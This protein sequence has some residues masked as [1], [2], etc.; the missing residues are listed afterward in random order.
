MPQFCDIF[1]KNVPIPPYALCHLPSSSPLPRNYLHT[2][3]LRRSNTIASMC[4]QPTE[5]GNDITPRPLHIKR[6]KKSP[7][8]PFRKR[9]RA[10]KEKEKDRASSTG[11]LGMKFRSSPRAHSSCA[12]VLGKDGGKGRTDWNGDF[13]N[14]RS[15][16]GAEWSRSRARMAWLKASCR[17]TDCINY[18]QR[19]GT[20]KKVGGGML[21]RRRVLIH[22]GHPVATYRLLRNSLGDSRRLAFPHHL[23][24][25]VRCE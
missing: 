5:K 3:D 17:K 16:K 25:L 12:G 20:A 15:R 6:V 23:W 19:I 9:G 8:M 18:P 21:S 2:F 11:F 24:N 13:N 14:A 1:Y 7:P 22:P 4:R 10:Q